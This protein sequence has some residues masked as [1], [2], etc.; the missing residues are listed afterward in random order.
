MSRPQKVWPVHE[1]L[2]GVAPHLHGGVVVFKVRGIGI[3]TQVAPFADD[4]VAEVAVVAFVAVAQQD[5]VAH[6]A[7]HLRKRADGV[8]AAQL[9]AGIH[10]AALA[11]RQRALDDGTLVHL[12]IF[13]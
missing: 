1:A 13:A 4:R 8:I 6:F 9:G 11:Q 10:V 7:A 3:G 12:R 2:G 5:A